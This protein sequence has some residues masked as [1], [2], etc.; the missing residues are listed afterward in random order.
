MEQLRAQVKSIKREKMGFFIKNGDI[1]VINKAILYVR[2][3]EDCAA[4][5]II[6]CFESEKSIP[7]TL[8]RDV[9]ILNAQYPKFKIDLILAKGKFSPAMVAY[10]STKLN[11]PR[12]LFFITCPS[13]DFSL[14]IEEL[15]GVRMI[16]H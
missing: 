5:H 11:I 3:N 1:S 7:A 12:N 15:G 4:L 10:L 6:H 16:T 14:K 13:R 9:S 2:S 8:Y